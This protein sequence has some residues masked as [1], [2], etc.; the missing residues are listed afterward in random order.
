MKQF[1]P[2]LPGQDW[3]DDML[4]EAYASLNDPVLLV[5]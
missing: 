5:P 2:E 1:R 3:G 4:G